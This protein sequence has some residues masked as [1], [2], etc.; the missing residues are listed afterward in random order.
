[1]KELSIFLKFEFSNEYKEMIERIFSAKI[2]TEVSDNCL[3]IDQK[4]N[5]DWKYILNLIQK[6]KESINFQFIDFYF[7][8]VELD[9]YIDS[10]I[11]YIRK[12]G[13]SFIDLPIVKY[14]KEFTNLKPI[15][16]LDR[17]GIIN[18][19]TGYVYQFSKEIIFKDIIDVIKKAN[20]LDILV[21]IVTNQAGV[22]RGKYSISE[23]NEF[24][25]ELRE[26][27]KEFS[28]HIDHIEICPFHFEKGNPPWNFNSILRKPMPGMLLRG[29]AAVG[30]TLSQSL[31]IGDKIS[32][33]ISI[34]GPESILIKNNYEI[35]SE[36]NVFESRSQ[37]C[38]ETEKYLNK[39]L[40]FS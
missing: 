19:D 5:V 18:K 26:Y 27:L 31:M 16:F 38:S 30:G 35:E 13:E 20:S 28:A 23:V 10:G 21:V 37:F 40:D 2:S 3:V 9:R 25:R 32:D 29:A 24:H 22:A 36:K 34:H 7:E 4:L 33:R 17:D 39:M 14:E 15:F 6:T 11:R 12:V 8:E 1:M